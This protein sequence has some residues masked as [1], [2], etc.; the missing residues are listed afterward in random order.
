M[1]R[2]DG[3]ARFEFLFLVFPLK[4][5]NS[6]LGDKA[7]RPPELS[8]NAHPVNAGKI[9]DMKYALMRVENRIAFP[10][11]PLETIPTACNTNSD[12]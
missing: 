7:K 11:H 6:K 5:L 10:M 4:S 12:E 1:C 9:P 3:N 2:N 8:C